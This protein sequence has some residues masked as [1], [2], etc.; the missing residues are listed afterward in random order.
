MSQLEAWVKRAVEGDRAAAEALIAEVRDDVFRLCLRM[1]GTR[2]DAEDAA[3]EIVIKVLTHLAQFR[4]DSSF[5]TW[6]WRIATHH[7]LRTRQ[8][9]REQV[10]SFETIEMLISKGDENPPL[11][12]FSE[13]ELKLLAEEVRLSCTQAMVL[14]LDRDHRLSWILAEVFEL[15][16]DTAAQ[17]LEIE[18][19]AHRKR[20]S[21]ARER[22]GSWMNLHCGLVNAENLCR[23]V[24]QIPVAMGFGV[25]RLDAREYAG[26]GDPPPRKRLPL[27]EE[28]GQIE[29]AA[30]S[31]TDHPEYVAPASLIEKIRSLIDSGRWRMFDA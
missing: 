26:L 16:G 29:A 3:Q 25:A 31:L 27:V 18:P 20:L 4:G 30:C 17:V 1:L 11:P 6:V 14:S 23:C 19:A 9:Q 13:A 12:A 2:A 21:R 10:A 7:V 28:A 5:R 8:R 22:L 24:R 15:D